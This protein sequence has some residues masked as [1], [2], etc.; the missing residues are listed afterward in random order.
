MYSLRPHK[1]FNFV[2]MW[3]YG[4]IVSAIL[5][6]L[7]IAGIVT[8]LVTTGSAL[9]LGTEFS[10][11]TSIQIS[12]AGDLTEDTL[13]NTYNSTANELGVSSQISSAQTT[14]SGGTSGFLLRT[15]DSDTTSENSVMSKVQE[16]L[17]IDSDNVT[18]QTISASWGASV[19]WSSVFAFIL[20]C[21]AILIVI[22]LR[23]REPR[24]GV[25]ALITLFHDMFIVVGVY[26]W[27]GMFFHMEITAD[28]IAA[29]LAIIGYSLYDTIVVF[30]RIN[31][32][33]SPNMRMSMK[34]CANIS[35]NEII[36]RSLN[37]SITSIIPVF[38]ML[39]LGTDTLLDFAFA[40][41]IGMVLGVYSTL[42]ISAPVYTLWKC[43]QPEYAR[44]E[45]KFPYTVEQSPFTKPMLKQARKDWKKERAEEKAKAAEDK[46]QAKKQAAEDKKAAAEEKKKAAAQAREKAVEAKKAQ[47]EKKDAGKEKGD[48]EKAAAEKKDAGEKVEEAAKPA[49]PAEEKPEK[50]DEPAAE[51]KP[52][53]EEEPEADVKAGAGEKA[54]GEKPAEDAGAAGDAQAA[55]EAPEDADGTDEADAEEKSD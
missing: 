25:V 23:Y 6:A 48:A 43:R 42:A 15:T 17:G 37:T 55:G 45:K 35:V 44:L 3:K 16:S 19:I 47:A 40:M 51:E 34:T 7:S 32:N 33:A 54:E 13:V 30:H 46:K 18:I 26:A 27:A 11:G 52:V 36:V 14:S 10:G 31:Q 50:A 12:N 20:S 53:P 29:L 49:E 39:L 1:Q 38:F 21:V 2:G 28:V 4:F 22:A 9:T 24:M 8:S 41:F 5:I